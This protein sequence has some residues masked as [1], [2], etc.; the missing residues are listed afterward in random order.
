MVYD[1]VQLFL[2]M[3]ACQTKLE[4]GKSLHLMKDI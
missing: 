4:W 3:F 2:G 1:T